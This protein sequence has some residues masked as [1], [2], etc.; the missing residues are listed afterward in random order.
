MGC[1]YCSPDLE[2]VINFAGRHLVMSEQEISGFKFYTI[3]IWP[4]LPIPRIRIRCM[5]SCV[6]WKW[7]T[8]R[9]AWSNFICIN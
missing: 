9:V 4:P 7:M 6:W 3:F 8:L 1:K 2:E 5:G